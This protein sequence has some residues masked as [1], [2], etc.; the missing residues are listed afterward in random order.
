MVGH[1]ILGTIENLLLE[2]HKADR[3]FYI[4]LDDI[5]DQLEFHCNGSS[6]REEKNV[7]NRLTKL[8]ENQNENTERFTMHYLSFSMMWFIDEYFE[9]QLKY[10]GM[11]AIAA[12]E[13]IA[14]PEKYNYHESGFFNS[15]TPEQTLSHDYYHNI[16]S[17]KNIWENLSRDF[18]RELFDICFMPPFKTK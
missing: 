13:A 2:Y 6:Y 4:K 5:L 11:Y 17:C 16:L 7:L 12:T 9:S 1:G 3:D 14:Q 8:F 10:H 15:A 18:K